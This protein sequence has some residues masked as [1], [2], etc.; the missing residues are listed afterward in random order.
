MI[1]AVPLFQHSPMLGHIDSSQTVLRRFS[2][3]V[4]RT[5]ENPL[6]LASFARSQ[7]G[8]P[9]RVIDG[10]SGRLLMPSFIAA[11]PVEVVYLWPD[12]TTG[13]PRNCLLLA[14]NAHVRCRRR[15]F[16]HDSGDRCPIYLAASRK[17]PLNDWR[18]TA[19][20]C[21]VDLGGC[22]PLKI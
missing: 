10:V 20:G 2:R 7:G 1:V 12:G 5:A 4:C 19:A 6:P 9:P 15:L 13:I 21:A 18:C 14:M 11:N 16:S 8:L 17:T 3:T 22:K